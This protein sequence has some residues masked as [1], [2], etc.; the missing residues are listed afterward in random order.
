MLRSRLSVCKVQETSIAT[1]KSLRLAKMSSTTTNKLPR[2]KVSGS[3][4]F[5]YSYFLFSFLAFWFAGK[6]EAELRCQ[7]GVRIRVIT[8]Q[9]AG[10]GGD[11]R[12]HRRTQALLE[13]VDT[14]ENIFAPSSLDRICEWPTLPLIYTEACQTPSLLET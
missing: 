4:V 10:S 11:V 7:L 9:L 12:Q 6:R 13:L 8:A 14:M 5:S 2:E 3:E 1:Q